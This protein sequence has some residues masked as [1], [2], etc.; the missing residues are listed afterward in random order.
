MWARYLDSFNVG[1]TKVINSNILKNNLT[2][3]KRQ[4]DRKSYL[5]SGYK[6]LANKNSSI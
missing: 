4:G 1:L 3:K 5:S 6:K 2:S